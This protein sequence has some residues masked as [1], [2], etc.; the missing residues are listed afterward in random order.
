M[1]AEV[2]KVMALP[3]LARRFANQRADVGAMAL[4]EFQAFVRSQVDD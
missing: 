1:Q 4:A 2:V 3:D